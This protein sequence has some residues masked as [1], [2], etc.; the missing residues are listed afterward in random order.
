L[1]EVN[2]GSFL[3]IS[4]CFFDTNV[5]IWEPTLSSNICTECTFS[6]AD[7]FLPLGRVGLE[8]TWIQAG[9]GGRLN[10]ECVWNCGDGLE[11]RCLWLAVAVVVVL[12]DR[13]VGTK[14]LFTR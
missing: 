13:L 1:F 7:H 10:L 14:I 12:E 4:L 9:V 2:L 5:S 3:Q 6:V 8:V 11:D